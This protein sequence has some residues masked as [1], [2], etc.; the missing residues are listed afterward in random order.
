MPDA[1]SPPGPAVPPP[2]HQDSYAL[3]EVLAR[4][5]LQLQAISWSDIPTARITIIAGRILREG[6][7]VDGYAVVEIRPND[8][9]VQKAGK[10]WKLVYG[11]Q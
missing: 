5:A 8:V 3:T 6:Q 7:N 1:T 4:D 2:A 10:H 11:G 9:I